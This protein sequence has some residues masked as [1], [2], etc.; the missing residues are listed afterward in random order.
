MAG[1]GESIV[2]QLEELKGLKEQGIL[3]QEEFDLAKKKLLRDFTSGTQ[4]VSVLS[5]GSRGSGRAGPSV[6][7]GMKGL[8]G[9]NSGGNSG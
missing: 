3:T 6:R 1:E 4:P 5:P 9:E 7:G 2:D 8:F